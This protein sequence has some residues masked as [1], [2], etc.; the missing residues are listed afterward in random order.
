MTNSDGTAGAGKGGRRA[1][2]ERE[3]APEKSKRGGRTTLTQ[4]IAQKLQN[5][6]FL[7]GQNEVAITDEE[8]CSQVDISF[9]QLRGWLQR[10]TKPVDKDGKKGHLG[11]RDIRTRARARTK[12]QYLQGILQEVRAASADGDHRTAMDGYEWLLAK[13]FPK[14]YGPNAETEPEKGD[15]P[16]VTITLDGQQKSFAEICRDMEKGQHGAG[17]PSETA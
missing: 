16:E 9:G 17:P 14:S 5:L 13:Q 4:E 6:W 15:V 8:I 7:A 12:F 1:R 10:N 11:M 2:S 3:T